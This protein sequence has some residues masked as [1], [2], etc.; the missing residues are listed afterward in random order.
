VLKFSFK[1][2]ATYVPKDNF[3]PHRTIKRIMFIKNYLEAIQ[4][5]DT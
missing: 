2:V 1:R 5:P 3:S 4:D